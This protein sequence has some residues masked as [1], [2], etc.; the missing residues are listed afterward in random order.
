MHK[1]EEFPFPVW[2]DGSTLERFLLPNCEFQTHTI[3]GFVGMI[4][5]QRPEQLSLRDKWTP[6]M[7]RYRT[8]KRQG[9][10]KL[11][12]KDRPMTEDGLVKFLE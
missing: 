1:L 2:H 8:R 10:K 11:V 9:R 5:T 6:S 3:S 4:T 7:E 12:F